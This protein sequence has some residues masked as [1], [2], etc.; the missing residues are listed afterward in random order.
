[1]ERFWYQIIRSKRKTL[2]LTVTREGEVVVR[3][4]YAVSEGYVADFVEKH[5]GWI[6]KRLMQLTKRPQISLSDGSKLVLFG[7]A[8]F[9]Q[10]GTARIG[11]DTV[12]LPREGREQALTRLLKKL[13]LEKMSVLTAYVANRCGFHYLRVRISSAKGRWGSCNRE[14]VIAYTFRVAFLPPELYEYVIVH[15]LAHTVQF[16]HG[17]KF[18]ETVEK[19]LPDWKLRRK[20]LASRAEIM[21]L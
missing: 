4:P 9:I 17:P 18:W 11:D 19:V 13:A 1:M 12:Y 8:Y 6:Q 5:G 15:E 2:S 16:N 21:F 14:G 3:A 10:T 7:T 20:M